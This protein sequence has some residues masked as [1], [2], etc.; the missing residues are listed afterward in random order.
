MIERVAREL[1]RQELQ[2][3]WENYDAQTR[4]KYLTKSY[5]AIAAMREPTVSMVNEGG[6][7]TGL[8]FAHVDRAWQA[9]IDA[10]LE[11]A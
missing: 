8:A 2:W 4:H 3:P 11:E 9:M 5:A 1:L 10:A 7:V 6:R